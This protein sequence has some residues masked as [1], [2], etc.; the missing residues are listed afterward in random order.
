MPHR[1]VF[2]PVGNGDT[3]QIVLENGKRILMDYRHR[4]KTEDGE[5]PEIN[6]KARLKQELNDAGRDSFDVVAFTHADTDHIENST[7]FFELRHAE[8]YQGDGRIKIDTLWVPAAMIL[9]TGTNDQQ[10][11]E[12]V[13][14]RQ[15]AR[16]RLKEGKGIRVFSRPEKLK[17]WLEE[18]GLTLESRR[19]LIT[20][21]GQIAPD[22]DIVIDGVEFFCHSPFIKHVDEGDDLRND[23]SLIF[24]V[25]FR[26]NGQNY[27][28]LAVGDS[29]WSVL[30]DIVETTKAH[31]NM[32]RLAW[33]LYNIPHHCSYLSLSDDKGEFETTPKPLV[34][35]I[36]LSGKDGAYIVSSS[37]PILDTKD[38]REQTQPPHI[39]AK[40][41]YETF[42]KK[43]GGA[44]F[45]VTMEEPNATT[46]EPLEFKV[47]S[48]GLSLAR[49]AASAVGIIISKP[50]P[51]AG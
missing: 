40:K 11:A 27:D 35:E 51:R 45:L 3:S 31:G 48:Q 1:I 16:H 42:R 13:I 24:N 2:Y 29:T 30:E 18:N 38:G 23:A 37:C 39:Q 15:E 12:F 5:G 17:G 22:F 46:P 20:D 10:M 7:E 49:A 28:Y 19:H 34:E 9:E 6:L 8:K 25:R 26:K 4:K 36:L 33:D 14:W 41:C 43:T 47:D 32:D 21:A 44:K 50:A